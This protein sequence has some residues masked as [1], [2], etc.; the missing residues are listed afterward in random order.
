MAGRSA[1]LRL[2][3]VDKGADL[4]TVRMGRFV[5]QFRVGVILRKVGLGRGDEEL[6][7][8]FRQRPAIEAV[9]EGGADV[10]RGEPAGG[11]LWRAGLLVF[12]EVAWL[13]A[14]LVGAVFLFRLI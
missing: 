7:S 12:L 4:S 10:V 8:W 3:G 6:A 1:D 11:D 9:E 2:A 14:L 5:R 13:T